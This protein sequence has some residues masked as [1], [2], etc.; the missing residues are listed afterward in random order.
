MSYDIILISRKLELSFQDFEARAGCYLAEFEDGDSISKLS[1]TNTVSF[2]FNPKGK[3]FLTFITAKVKGI[4]RHQGVLY[5][6]DYFGNGGELS[7]SDIEQTLKYVDTLVGEKNKVNSNYLHFEK[8]LASSKTRKF[9]SGDR[10]FIVTNAS[11]RISSILS[12]VHAA[13]PMK[14]RPCK[15]IQNEKL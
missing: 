1:R 6:T 9:V 12:K 15:E 10:L 3:F 8:N 4:K 7:M 2:A 13:L 11:D 14:Q 5:I